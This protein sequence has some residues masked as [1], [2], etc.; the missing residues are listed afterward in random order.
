MTQPTSFTPEQITTA[1]EVL[2]AAPG[3]SPTQQIAL[4]EAGLVE[5]GMRNLP[6][7]DLDSAGV[8]QERPSQ[9]WHNVTNVAAATQQLIAHMNTSLT[10][11]GAM[12]QSA[13]RSGAPAKYGQMQSQAMALLAAAEQGLPPGTITTGNGVNMSSTSGGITGGLTSWLQTIG[14]RIGLLVF[15]GLLMLVGVWVALGHKPS[16]IVKTG[17]QRANRE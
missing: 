13:E 9:G 4:M 17:V 16:D 8:F 3:A 7:G 6:S 14:P 15:G 1:Q 12:A 2:K 10:D 5:S 11:P